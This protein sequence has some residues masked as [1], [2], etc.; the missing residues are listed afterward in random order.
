MFG[1]KWL[2]RI[3]LALL[4]GILLACDGQPAGST[5]QTQAVDVL[6]ATAGGAWTSVPLG[7]SQPLNNGD[8]VSTSLQGEGLLKRLFGNC[9]DR[10]PVMHLFC[11]K[12]A[13]RMTAYV[14]NHGNSQ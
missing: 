9:R 5:I 1:F 11:G 14:K 10:Q 8:S 12:I 4:A 3:V 7:S 13:W 6:R 2:S